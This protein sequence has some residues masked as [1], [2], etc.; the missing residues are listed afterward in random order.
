M[1]AHTGEEPC[2][3]PPHLGLAWRRRAS[4]LVALRM[5]I[6][7][8]RVRAQVS[9]RGQASTVLLGPGGHLHGRQLSRIQLLQGRQSR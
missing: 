7:G 4:A 1:H 6:G 9:L 5:R 2:S 3:M 8:R